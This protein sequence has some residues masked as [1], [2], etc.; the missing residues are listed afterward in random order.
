MTLL[1][2]TLTVVSSLKVPAPVPAGSSGRSESP[3][4][5]PLE[6]P[7]ESRDEFAVSGRVTARNAGPTASYTFHL[8]FPPPGRGRMSGIHEGATM[9]QDQCK[10]EEDQG[11]A[12]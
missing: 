12:T 10:A 11:Q 5:L 6:E 7:M 4:I 1:S 2:S 9:T 3:Q 8:I